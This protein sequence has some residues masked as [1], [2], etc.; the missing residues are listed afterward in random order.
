M[1][2]CSAFFRWVPASDIARAW[3]AQTSCLR[4]CQQMHKNAECTRQC[5][6]DADVSQGDDS[7]A[8]DFRQ[9]PNSPF[10]TC[11]PS[12]RFSRNSA[13]A[14]S[15]NLVGMVHWIQ[16]VSFS[17][18]DRFLCKSV[19]CSAEGA[20]VNFLHR[21]RHF[22]ILCRCHKLC[23]SM[24]NTLH[25]S[26]RARL[27]LYPQYGNTHAAFAYFGKSTVP[28]TI[29]VVDSLQIIFFANRQNFSLKMFAGSVALN[30]TLAEQAALLAQGKTS[31]SVKQTRTC[32]GTVI[33]NADNC[34]AEGFRQLSDTKHYKLVAELSHSDL[35]SEAD[36][37]VPKLSLLQ[38][39]IEDICN[40]YSTSLSKK[41]LT[42]LFAHF[43]FKPAKFYML[44]K[45]TNHQD[46]ML[47]LAD[48]QYHV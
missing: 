39:E 18:F 42:A 38:N 46:L 19:C 48:L 12:W 9:F 25:I 8:G 30:L 4:R 27:Y 22:S 43:P 23:K 5:W 3:C 15:V 28:H 35:P 13:N 33:L 45:F 32:M 47:F 44:P 10:S 41:G 26:A 7:K 2:S 17:D 37:I 24:F 21:L 20:V 14:H 36:R 16:S 1:R 34:H 31:R 11:G 6:G 29:A 40:K